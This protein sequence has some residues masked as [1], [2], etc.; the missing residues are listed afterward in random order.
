VVDVLITVLV[1]VAGLCVDVLVVDMVE[2]AVVGASDVV[3]VVTIGVVDA[4][5]VMVLELGDIVVLL[6]VDGSV[7]SRTR[8]KN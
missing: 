3:L 6:I 2:V 4:V 1:L 7:S 5:V 8:M